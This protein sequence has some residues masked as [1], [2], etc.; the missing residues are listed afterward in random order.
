[1]M[2]RLGNWWTGRSRRE[3]WLLGV[4][5]AL[6]AAVMLWLGVW[7]PVGGAL[8]AARDRHDA[9]MTALARVEA[10]VAAV[11]A[12]KRAPPPPL[13]APLATIVGDSAGEAGFTAAG[14]VP[15]GTGRVVV[16]IA[17]V[18]PIAFFAWID[19]LTRR[20]IVIER[21]S[22]RANSD[23]TLTVEVTLAERGE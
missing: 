10:Q 1:M 20:G 3:Q 9:A 16:T 6:L 5:I 15:Q 14:V 8:S 21:L 7:R 23:P 4:M 13:G 11:R 22:S 12:L 17:S 18:R 2:E 19:A